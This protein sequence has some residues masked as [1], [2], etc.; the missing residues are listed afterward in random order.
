VKRL[1]DLRNK[2]IGV[3]LAAHGADEDICVG[4]QDMEKLAGFYDISADYLF[5]LTDLDQYRNIEI[6]SLFQR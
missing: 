4:Y 6:Q 3:H 5:V 1:K 2:H